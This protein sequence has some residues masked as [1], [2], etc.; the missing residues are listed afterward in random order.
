MTLTLQEAIAALKKP[1][2]DWVHPV[3]VVVRAVQSGELIPASDARLAVALAYQRAADRARNRWALRKEHADKLYEMD[4]PEANIDSKTVSAKADEAEAIADEILALA[5]ADDLAEGQ[6]LREDKKGM[7]DQIGKLL[8]ILD[9]WDKERA[10][11]L[12]GGL[13]MHT[14]GQTP[15]WYVE[16]AFWACYGYGPRDA[17]SAAAP[18]EDAE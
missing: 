1:E 18:K 17:R 11:E 13:T 15:D 7:A 8:A 4:Y 10:D 16:A 12:N 3:D 14:Y 5:P 2:G 9:G 6:A